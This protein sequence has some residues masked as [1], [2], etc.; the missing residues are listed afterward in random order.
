[1]EMY[2]AASP[3]WHIANVKTPT[4]I[5]HG[6]ADARVH[7]AQ[8]MEYFRALKIRGV[9]VRFVRYPREK[10]GISERAHQIVLMDRVVDWLGRYL[11]PGA[12]PAGA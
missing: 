1:M 2:W 12:S 11:P 8:G 7:P 4:L 5:L 6:D 3:I 9:P 10:H